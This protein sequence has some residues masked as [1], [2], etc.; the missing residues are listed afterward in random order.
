MM[1][2]RDKDTVSKGPKRR[3]PTCFQV[4]NDIV[5]PAGTI[6]RSHGGGATF[7]AGIEGGNFVV[8]KADAEALSNFK[9][10]VA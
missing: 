5:I 8:S 9:R 4:L 1:Q 3:D 7:E 2:M 6:L 10:V